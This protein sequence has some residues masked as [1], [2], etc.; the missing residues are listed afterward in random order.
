MRVAV[1]LQFPVTCPPLPMLLDAHETCVEVDGLIQIARGLIDVA[2]AA[3]T[4][5][6][7]SLPVLRRRYREEARYRG[8]SPSGHT[9]LGNHRARSSALGRR[10]PRAEQASRSRIR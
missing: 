10:S 2:A 8:P 5:N 6:H 7:P 1:A 3:W 4:V 9:F